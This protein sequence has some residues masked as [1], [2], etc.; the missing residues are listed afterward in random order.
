MVFKEGE[1]LVHEPFRIVHVDTV[2]R[3]GDVLELSCRKILPD[4]VVR[5]A[6]NITGSLT[7]QEPAS[8]FC[9]SFTA[10]FLDIEI[11]ISQP[12]R[13]LCRKPA[14]SPQVPRRY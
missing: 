10:C 3:I 1:Q 5:V 7:A 6:G 11:Y 9:H 13:L 14:G 12:R 2:A 4:A 8:Q